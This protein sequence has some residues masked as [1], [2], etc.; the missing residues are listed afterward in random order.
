MDRSRMKRSIYQHTSDTNTKENTFSV[1][2]NNQ[3]TVGLIK[4]P[5]G[6]Y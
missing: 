1:V 5:V 2:S 4:H 6:V 3:P